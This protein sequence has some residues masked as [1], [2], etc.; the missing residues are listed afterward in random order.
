[1]KYLYITTL[2]GRQRFEQ[3]LPWDPGLGTAQGT[4]RTSSGPSHP[5]GTTHAECKSLGPS[6]RPQG[7]RSAFR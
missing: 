6:V 1:M 4:S 5:V 2:L 3:Q 7:E